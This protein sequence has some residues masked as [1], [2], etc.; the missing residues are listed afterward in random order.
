V[1]DAPSPG[2]RQAHWLGP[3][4][5]SA[6]LL[7]SFLFTAQASAMEFTN[8]FVLES[9]AGVL[10]GFVLASPNF[11]GD[12]GNC[13]F[14][15]H[16][17]SV[18]VIETP[19]GIVISELKVSGEH[20]WRKENEA[21]AVDYDGQVFLTIEQNGDVLDANGEDIGRAKPLPSKP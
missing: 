17:A 1:N 6:T 20:A 18:S 4:M 12:G 14:M 19:L 9:K 16:P 15:L 11:K 13:I 8:G 21:I 3:A 10:A 2:E 7:L 5:K